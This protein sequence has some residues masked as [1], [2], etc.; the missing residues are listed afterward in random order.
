MDTVSMSEARR[1]LS[2][3]VR[4]AE[5]GESVTI[6]RRGK[7]VAR[8]VPARRER[9]RALPDLSEFRASIEVRGKPLSQTVID[10]RARERY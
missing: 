4:A 7:Q 3:L 9:L 5:R 10:M 8:I 6:T 1:R 2:D